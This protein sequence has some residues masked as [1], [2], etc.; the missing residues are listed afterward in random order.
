MLKGK[1]VILR[2]IEAND[3]PLLHQWRN[4]PNVLYEAYGEEL[5]PESLEST[6]K[7]ADSWVNTEFKM[8]LGVE[9]QNKLVGM[10]QYFDMDWRV[11]R[12]AEHGVSICD[13]AAQK[14]SVGRDALNTLLGYAFNGMNLHRLW[15]KLPAYL[16]STAEML[17]A[18][19]GYVRE[20]RLREQYYVAG[21]YVDTVVLGL[22]R[23]DYEKSRAVK[24]LDAVLAGP[25]LNFI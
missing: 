6:K 23:K 4:S 15:L 22:L 7:W 2:A 19:F 18:D 10:A 13:P 1:N 16:D 5:P 24:D 3:I 17:I 8:M 14:S 20:G 9:H 25:S 21:K 12:L 11:Y